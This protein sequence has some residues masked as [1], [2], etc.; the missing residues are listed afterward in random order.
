LN[1][2]SKKAAEKAA[3]LSEVLVKKWLTSVAVYGKILICDE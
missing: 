3:F 1:N 2:L